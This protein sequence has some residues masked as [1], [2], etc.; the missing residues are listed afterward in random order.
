MGPLISN[1]DVFQCIRNPFNTHNDHLPG[2]C[3]QVGNE[4]LSGNSQSLRI[5][6]VSL[7]GK[8]T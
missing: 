3:M 8:F 7:I 4:G 2:W 5:P 1:L 6:L